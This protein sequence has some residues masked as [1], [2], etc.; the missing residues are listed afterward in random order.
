MIRRQFLVEASALGL[1]GGVAGAGLGVLG[2]L[3]IPHF[4]SNKIAISWP[5]TAGAI[6]VA[7]GIGVVF[8]VYPASRAA[9]LTPI[10]ALRSD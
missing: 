8:G 4:V 6:V 10:E 9:R 7:M 5:A 3:V 1:A 2:A